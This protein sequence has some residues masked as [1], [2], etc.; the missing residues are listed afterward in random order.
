MQEKRDFIYTTLV[1][2]LEHQNA[3]IKKKVFECLID[4]CRLYYR[5]LEDKIISLDEITRIYVK[6]LKKNLFE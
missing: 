4:L 6:L 3:K 5:F 2:C 1:E